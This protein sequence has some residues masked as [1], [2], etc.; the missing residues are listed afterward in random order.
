MGQELKEKNDK[1]KVTKNH[2]ICKMP[3]IQQGKTNGHMKSYDETLGKI[4]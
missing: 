3:G 1:S 2:I 4:F